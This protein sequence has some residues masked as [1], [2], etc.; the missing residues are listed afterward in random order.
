M[1][2]PLI[3]AL[4]VAFVALA[5]TAFVA[6]RGGVIGAPSSYDVSAAKLTSMD[7]RLFGGRSSDD[8][9]DLTYKQVQ[10]VYYKPVD[11][12][13]LIS[14]ERRGL[15]AYMKSR[16]IDGSIPAGPATGRTRVGRPA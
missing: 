10:R 9:V 1:I 4:A 7:L 3:A 16:H 6:Y 12:Q 8:L 13:A 11:S 14:G 5:C 15:L 2:R